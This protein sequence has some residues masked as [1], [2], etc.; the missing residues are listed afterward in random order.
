MIYKRFL[1]EQI[2]KSHP[3]S[4]GIKRPRKETTGHR[5]KIKEQK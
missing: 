5:R 4:L 3:L 2:D 1:P